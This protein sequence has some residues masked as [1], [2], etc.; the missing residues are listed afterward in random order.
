M[1][2]RIIIRAAF[3]A[4]LLLATQ[5]ARAQAPTPP[6]PQPPPTQPSSP[7]G[8]QRALETPP[9]AIPA[10]VIDGSEAVM[11][12]GKPVKSLKN[13]DLGRVIDVVIDRNG[14]LRAAVIDFGGFLGVGVRKI[15]VDWRALHFPEKGSMDKLIADLPRD[16]LKSAPAVKEGESIVVIGA[17]E[18]KIS[19]PKFSE[20]KL[21]EQKP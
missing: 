4:T 5:L 21:Q 9:V 8:E 3:C 7:S 17:P 19:E 16:G 11:L 20:P 15:A 13:E 1:A 18:P 14:G 10:V 6:Q 12:L 2:S